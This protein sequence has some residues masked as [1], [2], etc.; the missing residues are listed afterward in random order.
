MAETRVVKVVIAEKSQ[1]ML[2]GVLTCA[3]NWVMDEGHFG[4]G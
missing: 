3:G 4:V 1:M 2:V